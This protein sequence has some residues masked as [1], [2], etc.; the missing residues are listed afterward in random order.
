MSQHA[1]ERL[2]ERFSCRPEKALKLVKKAWDSEEVT[3]SLMGKVSRGG[4]RPQDVWKSF[5]GCL[6]V[7]DT[8]YNNSAHCIT[9]IN[10]R[11]K[12]FQT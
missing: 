3:P 10:P 4:Q 2:T 1:R 12:E 5:L 8:R 9:V 11:I 6:F 7:F